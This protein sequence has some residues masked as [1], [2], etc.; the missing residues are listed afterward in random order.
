MTLSNVVLYITEGDYF[1]PQSPC[2]LLY[3]YH[4]GKNFKILWWWKSGSCIWLH[5]WT[6][7][8]DN[9]SGVEK[10]RIVTHQFSKISFFT[11][12]ALTFVHH[13]LDQLVWSP[14]WMSCLTI[15]KLFTILWHIHYTFTIALYQ[16]A[17][18]SVEETCVTI[19]IQFHCE[20]FHG[21]KFPVSLPLQIN[22][23]PK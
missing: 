13:M 3:L 15:C 23:Y 8:T 22:R 7:S 4:H 16:L 2:A 11:C 12:T 14:T 6:L 10:S 18:T 21:T 19:I 20:L 17:V 5:L 9:P 1:S